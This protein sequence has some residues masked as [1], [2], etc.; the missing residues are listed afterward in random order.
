MHAEMVK[1][2]AIE[3]GEEAGCAKAIGQAV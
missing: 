3:K 2:I 1:L